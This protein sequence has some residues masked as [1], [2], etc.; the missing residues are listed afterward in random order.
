MNLSFDTFRKNS[1]TASFLFWQVSALVFILHRYFTNLFDQATLNWPAYTASLEALHVSLT[2]ITVP[3]FRRLSSRP[4]GSFGTWFLYSIVIAIAISLLSTILF[5]LLILFTPSHLNFSPDEWS[6][7]IQRS[8]LLS[9]L[10]TWVVSVV[11]LVGF[12]AWR[13]FQQ[14]QSQLQR[15]SKLREELTQAQM[16]ML[17]MQV[18]PHF[19]F[20][21]FNTIAMMIRTGRSTEANNM[22]AMVADLFRSSLQNRN[23]DLVPLREEI[24]LCEQLLNIERMR[25][26]DRLEVKLT[27]DATAGE[28]KVPAL[29]L[30]P[31]IENAFKHGLMD[32]LSERQSFHVHAAIADTTLCIQIKNTG[33]LKSNIREG[34]GLKNVKER[35]RI[36]FG[37][38]AEHSLSEENGWVISKIEIKS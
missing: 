5:S 33:R 29:I 34:I 7:R 13:F 26:A 32:S 20:N 35:L 28:S 11:M 22:L 3:V 31:L 24:K 25:F 27:V 21:T 36:S 14:H 37:K 6:T 12:S 19:L 15:E 23:H 1:W 30:Q 8:L 10:I 18:N 4:P 17:R 9:P 38:N 16:Q 2:L